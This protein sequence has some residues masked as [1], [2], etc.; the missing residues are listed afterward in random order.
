MAFDP[1]KLPLGAELFPTPTYFSEVQFFGRNDDVTHVINLLDAGSSIAITGKRRIGRTWFLQHLRTVLP[2]DRYLIVSSDELK[3]DTI[4]PR[5]AGLFLYA[6]IYELHA[7]LRPH[8]PDDFHCVMLDLE[9]SRPNDS[10]AFF[11]DLKALHVYLE[12]LQLTA[13]V[14]IDE[15]EALYEFVDQP[16][17][18]PAIVQ[19]LTT[20]YEYLRIIVAGFD[21]R[22]PINN[23]PP[24][25]NS[26]AHRQLQ[27]IGSEGAYDL[28]AGQLAQHDVHFANPNVWAHIAMLTGEEPFMLRLLG[29]QLVEQARRNNGFIDVNQVNEAV[30]D[31]LSSQPVNAI[32]NHAWQVLGEDQY[33]H[34]LIAA[35]AYTP[36]LDAAEQEIFLERVL[37]QLY[38]GKTLK[39]LRS[40]LH[41]L[42]DLGYLF[43]D[44]EC[45]VYRFSSD[46][47]RQWICRNCSN[48][49]VQQG[50]FV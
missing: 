28:I 10:Q 34:S 18:V 36:V 35:L 23:Q 13:V 33:I 15:A 46:L 39:D 14:L 44:I 6:L 38:T 2:T 7:M 20:N 45:D 17:Q 8:L 41:R 22:S 29:Q 1:K 47:L 37:I 16:G 3:P 12:N 26:F 19:S 11:K 42:C 21:L 24:L 4:V 48:P 5:Q 25:F 43:E 50:A 30:N 49:G 9:H 40:N 31:F 32:L 27:G